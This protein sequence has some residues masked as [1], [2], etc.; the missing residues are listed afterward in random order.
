MNSWITLYLLSQELK[1]LM[2]QPGCRPSK[3]SGASLSGLSQR[4]DSTQGG[5]YVFSKAV[6]VS[7]AGGCRV[8]SYCEPLSCLLASH[9]SPH[10]TL[11]PGKTFD[12]LSVRNNCE[13]LDFCIDFK[14]S[15]G[16]FSTV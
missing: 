10:T 8:L 1:T 5:H 15:E 13:F 4:Q 6:L 3:N 16:I 9:P 12:M 7:Q 2:V 11:V 14:I